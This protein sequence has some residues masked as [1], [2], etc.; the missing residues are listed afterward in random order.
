MGNQFSI[1]SSDVRKNDGQLSL[2][3]SPTSFL[4]SQFEALLDQSMASVAAGLESDGTKKRQKETLQAN[5]RTNIQTDGQKNGA[6]LP[7]S[8]TSVVTP[9]EQQGHDNLRTESINRIF[10]EDIDTQSKAQAP[11]GVAGNAANADAEAL[12]IVP[13]Q[14]FLD[15]AIRSLNRVSRQEFKVND[16]MNR[17]VEGTVSE[18]DVVLETAKLNLSI[19]MVTTIIQSAVQTFK[20]IQNIPI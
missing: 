18:D 9:V 5:Q 4:V 1:Q 19:S 12:N 14:L 13:L 6:P 15:N 7:V 11:L 10:M 3:K 2:P 8:G 16:L 17:F 20:E